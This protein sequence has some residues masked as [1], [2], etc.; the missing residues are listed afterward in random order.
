MYSPIY[1]WKL[2]NDHK[3]LDSLAEL[4]I[5][6]KCGDDTS[7][8]TALTENAKSHGTDLKKDMDL[9]VRVLAKK[10]L[11]VLNRV[12]AYI[13][14]LKTEP[15]HNR[16]GSEDSEHLCWKILSLL[17]LYGDVSAAQEIVDKKAI[18]LRKLIEIYDSLG[19]SVQ[20]HSLLVRLRQIPNL[21]LTEW[22]Q[23]LLALSYQKTSS[24]MQH[25]L[26]DH[27]IDVEEY[28]EFRDNTE[29]LFPATNRAIRDEDSEVVERLL[30]GEGYAAPKL[31]L[32]KRQPLHIA[33]A[34]HRPH[35][36]Q[37]C[38]RFYSREVNARDLFGRTPLHYA[39]DEGDLEAFKTLI[40][41]G[42]DVH[43]CDNL[44]RSVLTYAAKGHVEIIWHMLHIMSVRPDEPNSRGT[45]GPLHQAAKNN[46]SAIIRLL[47]IHGARDYDLPD[48]R[49][50]YMIA[51]EEGCNEAFENFGDA[52][53]GSRGEEASIEASSSM[54]PNFDLD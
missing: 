25:I 7:H 36:L 46:Q 39:V 40:K 12:L 27:N 11:K 52:H 32:L 6:I 42:A 13:D 16:S 33:A 37:M 47:R 17:D 38:I 8:T 3:S 9:F 2:P 44:G 28:W 49:S 48:G 15:R 43:N 10:A 5:M 29:D 30:M 45:I 14:R 35:L 18:I 34:S 24:N 53:P 51:Q 41:A 1:L 23:Q 20:I 21:A 22:E 50:A 26:D 31:D 4:L 54:P 19:R